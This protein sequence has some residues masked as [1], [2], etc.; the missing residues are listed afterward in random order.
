MRYNV[1]GHIQDWTYPWPKDEVRDRFSNLV[2][3]IC[4]PLQKK[5]Q[6]L[7][8]QTLAE[9]NVKTVASWFQK[10]EVRIIIT[11]SKNGVIVT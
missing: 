10:L 9:Q 3:T 4:K 1:T 11:E 6:K 8:K 2:A 7:L 5:T